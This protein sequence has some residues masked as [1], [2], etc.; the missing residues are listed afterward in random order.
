MEKGNISRSQGTIGAIVLI[1]FKLLD[2]D[3][4]KEFTPKE[5]VDLFL[6]KKNEP[7]I[8]KLIE[9]YKKHNGNGDKED[10]IKTLEDP[11]RL[12]GW[13]DKHTCKKPVYWFVKIDD[14]KYKFKEELVKKYNLQEKINE[15]WS[16]ITSSK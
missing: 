11:S 14:N 1:I 5:I 15:L 3:S 7:I 2:C 4:S 6:D 10:T 12:K 9:N 8:Q 13:I 16:E